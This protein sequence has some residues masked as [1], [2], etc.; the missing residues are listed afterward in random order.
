ML[1]KCAGSKSVS[2]DLR[3]GAP[4]YSSLIRSG[5]P[6]E[7]Q[8][9][10]VPMMKHFLLWGSIMTRMSSSDESWGARH[11]NI[12]FSSKCNKYRFWHVLKPTSAEVWLYIRRFSLPWI[13]EYQK[14]IQIRMFLN[15][16]TCDSGLEDI[17]SVIN[18]C[19]HLASVA[20]LI[21]VWS[22]NQKEGCGFNSQSGHIP[23]L[24]VWSPVLIHTRVNQLMLFPHITL[25]LSPF[26]LPSSLS[27]SNEKISLGED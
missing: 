3:T 22:H 11:W 25:S 16:H 23:T 17:S 12:S 8:N 21:R 19:F 7:C 4:Q 26:S 2:S 10:G 15:Q 1:L 14:K 13:K 9:L 20:Q 18:L 5:T 24:W 27:K 6:D